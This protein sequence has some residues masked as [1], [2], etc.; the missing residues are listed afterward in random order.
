MLNRDVLSCDGLSVFY[1]RDADLLLT[2]AQL[3]RDVFYGYERV[4][5]SLDQNTQQIAL[6][7]L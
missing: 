1:A 7:I 4:P 3:F 2:Y 6:P 5:V